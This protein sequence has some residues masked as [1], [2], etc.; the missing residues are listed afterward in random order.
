MILLRRY[1]SGLLKS[2]CSPNMQKPKKVTSALR[3]SRLPASCSYGHPLLFWA[4]TSDGTEKKTVFPCEELQQ[5]DQAN[6]L[7][8][9]I[10]RAFQR[11][12]HFISSN[13]HA[14][15]LKHLHHKRTVSTCTLYWQTLRGPIRWHPEA[16]G[17][18]TA[19][20]YLANTILEKW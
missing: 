15:H 10:T 18:W 20:S 17:N 19:Q 4:G 6:P 1:W 11:L 5:G 13:N 14:F 7:L 8:K 16:R 9:L 12:V 3:H 2:D